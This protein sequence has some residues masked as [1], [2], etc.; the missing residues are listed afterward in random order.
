VASLPI[1][2]VISGVLNPSFRMRL[3][4]TFARSADNHSL[5]VE[6]ISGIETVK[7]MTVEPQ[8]VNRWDQQLAAYVSAGFRVTT[9]GNVGQQLIQLTGKLVTVI[10]L[11]LGARLVS[12]AD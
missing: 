2:A 12:T 9:L 8:F 7:S 6:T 11:F 1:Y 10:A 3:N 5:L 4:Q